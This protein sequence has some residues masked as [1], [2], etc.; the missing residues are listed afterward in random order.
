MPN[1]S[2]LVGPTPAKIGAKLQQYIER[3]TAEL[4]YLR[5]IIE[6]GAIG[7]EP[8]LNYAAMAADIRK[9]GEFG[10]LPAHNARRAPHKA[11]VIDEEGTLTYQQLD[12]AAH[13]VANGL[14]AKGVRGGDGV[15]I[16]ARNH[17]WFLIANYGAAR[18]GARIILLNSEF[19]GPQ[20]KE[21]SEREGAKIIIYDDEYTEAVSKAEPPLGKLR[22]LGVNPDADEPSGSTDETLAELIARSSTAPAPKASKH[23]SIIIL[24]S[25]TTGTPKGANRRTPPTLAPVGGILSHVPFKAGEVTSLPAPMFHALGYLHATLA[26]FLGSTL[27]LRRR[28]KPAL[29]VEDIEKH[30][31]TAL[32][33]VPVMLSR[34]LDAIEK[35]DT[36]PDLSSLKIVFVSGS[37]LGAELATR[38]LKDLGPVVYNMYGSTEVAFA[39]IAGPDDLQ[40]NPATVGPVVKGVKVKIL[41]DNG[42]EV[43]RGDVGRIFVGNAFPFE[44]YTGGGG[45]QII[46]GLLS[47][48]DVGYFDERGLLYVSG[49]DDEMIVSGG[50]NVF[51]AEVEDLISGHPDVVEATALGVDDKEWGARLRA[52]VVKKP[53]ATLDEDA[54]KQYVRD[55]LARY[56]VPRDVI[57]L[58][59]LPRNPTGKI[60]KREL[61]KL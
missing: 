10:M 45:K 18:V 42:N 31:A 19:S 27:L 54:I 53:G 32:V 60:L 44:G 38:A 41:D 61:R 9:W 56:K 13:A 33:V 29:V 1:L 4:H 6:S 28:F 47:S 14:L 21:V 37:Q 5:K 52:F 50:E 43:P 3:G 59:E 49:R 35:M 46:D 20:I 24:T 55:H 7:L 51:P 8:P 12:N 58:D 34:I 36:K 2:D 48:G 57:F 15:A 23:A 26:M 25:G 11:A 39:T 16:L 17:R 30:K 22:A 40:F